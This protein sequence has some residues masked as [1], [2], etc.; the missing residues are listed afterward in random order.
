MG[1]TLDPR[2]ADVA[3][4][5]RYNQLRPLL[6]LACLAII[7]LSIA[8]GLLANSGSVARL[9]VTP[10]NAGSAPAQTADSGA[11]LDHRGLHDAASLSALADLGARLDHRGVRGS[12][13][14]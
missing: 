12:S 13:S 2:H 4:R 7:G 11:R 5:S 14:H 1:Q 10:A 3:A 8:V 6:T 9:A